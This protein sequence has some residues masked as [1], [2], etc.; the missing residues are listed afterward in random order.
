MTHYRVLKR[1]KG[2]S[3]FGVRN[4]ELQSEIPHSALRTPHLMAATL[5][6]VSLEP[7]RTHPIRVHMAHLGYPVVGDTTYGKHPASFWQ[8]AGVSRQLLHAYAIRFTPPVT[9]LPIE[10]EAPIPDDMKPWMP[11]EVAS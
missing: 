9:K 3:E 8:A 7:G 10:L 1:F 11:A 6:E 5:L 2:S 4:S